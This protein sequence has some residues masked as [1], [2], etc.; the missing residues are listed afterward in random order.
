MFR[1]ASHTHAERIFRRNPDAFFQFFLIKNHRIGNRFAHTMKINE[2]GCSIEIR[3]VNNFA[4]VDAKQRLEFKACF[5]FPFSFCSIKN[6]LSWFHMPSWQKPNI[7][8]LVGFDQEDFS[9]PNN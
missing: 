4:E 5:L 1:S 9:F 6:R 8:P 7:P 2:M 3:I